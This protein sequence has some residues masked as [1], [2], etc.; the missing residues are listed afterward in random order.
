MERERKK[1][2]KR[3]LGRNS[4]VAQTDLSTSLAQSPLKISGD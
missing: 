1:E 3:D 4:V 2:R